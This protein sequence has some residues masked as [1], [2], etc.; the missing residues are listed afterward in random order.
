MG[1]AAGA[2][3]SP[4]PAFRWN[5]VAFPVAILGIVLAMITP[6][7]AGFLDFLISINIGLSLVTLLVSIYV[8]K[9][10]DFNLFP[11]V[12]LLMTLFRLA[13]NVSSSRLI[14]LNGNSGTAAAGHVIE[15]FGQFVVSGNFIVGCVVF[16]VLLA[17]QY[18]V[19]NHGAVRISE[20]TARFTLDAMPGK[21]M[22]I[23]ADLN[24]G[25]IDE[26]E[27]RR[28]RRELA[29]EAEFY[30]AMDGASRFTQR[31]AV[32]SII[33][34]VIN[35]LAGV[36]IG[37]VQQ[38]MDWVRALETYALLTVGDGLVTVVPALMI[39][40]TGGLIV[41]RASMETQL[42]DQ[43]QRQLFERWEPL[44]IAGGVL[45]A[46]ALLPGIPALPF[47]AVGGL[48]GWVGWTQ[49]EKKLAADAAPQPPPPVARPKKDELES[50]LRV[51]LL[52]IEV[53]L[54]LVRW[55]EG[56]P[57]SLLL[58]KIASIRKQLAADLGFLVPPVRVSDSLGLRSREYVI[59]L[60]G[61]EAGRFELVPGHDLALE[62]GQPSRKIS[63]M[64][65]TDPAFGFPAL[66]IPTDRTDEARLSG[67]TVVDGLA[68]MVTH[69]SELLKRYAH[70]LF[71]RQDAKV[72]LDRVAE[73]HPKAVEDLSKL[74]SLAVVQKVLQNLL[75]ERVS[76]RD[77]LSIVEAL[78]EAAAISRNQVLLTEYV[79]QALRRQII[80]PY[81]NATSSLP[82]YFL[83]PVWE[84]RL[85]ASIEHGEL[86]SQLSLPPQEIRE[87][88]ARAK[89]LIGA[90][91]APAVVVTTTSARYFLKQILD[92][93][94]GST[95]ALSH[96]EIPPGTK[97]VALGQIR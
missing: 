77:G 2:R 26:N 52:S 83:D 54:G 28:R 8:T 38:G 42:S 89:E 85:E 49:R 1:T 53:G 17:I 34:T 93:Q 10:A 46:L 25:L 30:G 20:V 31:D 48:T 63:G 35:I 61:V 18:V 13:L 6:I 60:K 24:N 57:S 40:V 92:T 4:Q 90:A 79:R 67:Y 55:L 70:E 62:S 58:R 73:E 5:D 96:S 51:D 76:I 14:L 80:Q 23:D 9:P 39:S 88:A 15:A 69:L 59:T 78:G 81:L 66:W 71:T 41:T 12:L 7:P 44:M 16:L 47:L 21:Q 72:F 37:V 56:G 86:A 97:L 22:S 82:C 94:L 87:L 32:A 95:H 91:E 75:R 19:I 68:V 84:K 65:A 64:A 36:L 3:L 27:A 29:S 43:V 11:T 33:I 74:V 45:L 50:S